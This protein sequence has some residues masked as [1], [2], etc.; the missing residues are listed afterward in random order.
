MGQKLLKKYLSILIFSVILFSCS[1]NIESEPKIYVTPQ[2]EIPNYEN[3][4]WINSDSISIGNQIGEG[5]I[6]LIDFWTY[7]CVNC[8]RTFPFLNEW[9]DK[10]RDDGLVIIGVHTPEFEFEKKIKKIKNS[11][12]KH[13]LS[14]P[15]VLDNDFDIWN[16]FNNRYWPAKYLFNARISLNS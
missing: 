6:V 16:E 7:T 12:N 2:H 9:D 3:M 5:K 1:E 10:Y 4:E 8:I 14:Y 15:V 13:N 11:M